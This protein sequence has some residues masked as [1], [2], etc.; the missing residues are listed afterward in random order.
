MESLIQKHSYAR[1]PIRT[2]GGEDEVLGDENQA[3]QNRGKRPS[4]IETAEVQACSTYQDGMA[5]MLLLCHPRVRWELQ[6]GACVC[7]IL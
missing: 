4:D 5:Y 3:T 1:S 2:Y 7:V 6:L